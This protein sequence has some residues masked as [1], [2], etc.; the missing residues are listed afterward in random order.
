MESE[1]LRESVIARRYEKVNGSKGV[2]TESEEE[3]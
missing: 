1:Q 3:E 2:K